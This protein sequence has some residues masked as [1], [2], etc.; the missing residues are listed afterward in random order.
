M[1]KMRAAQIAKAGGKFEVV[2]REI[3][4]P[5]P[6]QVRIKVEACG[7]CH[8]DMFVKSGGLDMGRVNQLRLQGPRFMSGFSRSS[9][10]RK[11]ATIGAAITG[12]KLAARRR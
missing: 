9:P 2:E 4:E 12:R 3:P 5:G 11:G 10:V 8:S 6:G 1:A 7:V